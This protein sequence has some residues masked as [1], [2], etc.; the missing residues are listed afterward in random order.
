MN[1][2]MPNNF[3][4][5]EPINNNPVMPNPVVDN[6]NSQLMG[7]QGLSQSVPNVMQGVPNIQ[8]EGSVMQGVNNVPNIPNVM[9]GNVAPEPAVPE[10]PVMP[11][12]GNSGIN[13]YTMQQT[14]PQHE[15]PGVVSIPTFAPNIPEPPVEPQIPNVPEPPVMPNPSMPNPMPEPPV[16][17]NNPLSN[18]AGIPDVNII[19]EPV[20]PNQVPEPP[21]NNMPTNNIIGNEQQNVNMVPPVNNIGM[22]PNPMN[23][24]GEPMP[25]QGI[26]QVGQT[27]LN[28]LDNNYTEMPEMPEK[29]FPL[30]V[31]EMVLIGIALIG[32]VI[33]LIVYL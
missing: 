30:S 22:T 24:I 18:P 14:E 13:A 26:S 28:S 15:E 16:M 19:G 17:P 1:N 27:E 9:Q 4:N 33:V 31:R 5:G 21:I 3:N 20:V 25:S 11:G 7:G 2:N 6:A 23:Q 12:Q 29:K 32:I 10:P 8:N